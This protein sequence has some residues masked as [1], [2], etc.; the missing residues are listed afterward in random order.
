[1]TPAEADQFIMRCRRVLPAWQREIDGAYGDAKAEAQAARDSV[2]GT[3]MEI[4]DEFPSKRAKIDRIAKE[5]R[6]GVW[7]SN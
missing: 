6:Y 7:A 4:A 2:L 5:Y 3:L 1:V